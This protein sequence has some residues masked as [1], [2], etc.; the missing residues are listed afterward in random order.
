MSN[1]LWI[2]HK[3]E[4]NAPLLKKCLHQSHDPVRAPF[5]I[6][7]VLRFFSISR[8]ASWTGRM[9]R[10]QIT[11][12]HTHARVQNTH[13]TRKGDAATCREVRLGARR[14][15]QDLDR[16][17]PAPGLHHVQRNPSGWCLEESGR[18][19]VCK[20]PMGQKYKPQPEWLNH[21]KTAMTLGIHRIIAVGIREL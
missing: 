9:E 8:D 12:T 19:S 7:W 14:Q 17:R 18:A 4:P 5:L 3:T 10:S 16:Q 13:Q 21:V 2:K 15:R 1:C 6:Q 20:L 11:T